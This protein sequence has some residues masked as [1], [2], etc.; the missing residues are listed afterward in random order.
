M[1]VDARKGSVVMRGAKSAFI[2]SQSYDLPAA[3]VVRLAAEVGITIAE[4]Y[5]YCVRAYDR[6]GRSKGVRPASF[7]A[8]FNEAV[9]E[10]GLQ[11]CRSLLDDYARKVRS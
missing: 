3:E 11:R 1:R 6:Q 5:V 9:A 4:G 7:E 10:L 2:R 8:R